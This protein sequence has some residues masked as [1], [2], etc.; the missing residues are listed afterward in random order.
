[1]AKGFKL[2]ELLSRYKETVK[3]ERPKKKNNV[4]K[5]DT[6]QSN[7]SAGQANESLEESGSAKQQD[8]APVDASTT[9]LSRKERRKQK[10]QQKQQ[11]KQQEE[12]QEE[13][14]GDE[15]AEAAPASLDLDKLARSDSESESEDEF[16]EARSV[17]EHEAEDGS[18][19]DVPLSDV[20]FDSDA[21]VVPHQKVT[22]NN[23]KAISD[24]LARIQLPWQ[25][26]SFQEH[27]T[28]TAAANADAGITDI[29]DDTE[30]E[31]AFYKQS[32]DA[33]VQARDAL[34]ALRV[35]FK[36]PLDYFAEMVK[37]DEHMDK[38][39]SKLVKEASD[40]KAREE[41]RKQ[42]QLKK[43]GK[44]VQVATL[45]QRQKEKRETLDKI[46]SLRTKRKH[47]DIDDDAFAVGVEDAAA[48]KPHKAG[49]KRQAKNAKYGQ[50][51]LKRFK[52]KNDAQSSAEMTD[53]STRKMKGKAPRPGK[54]KRSRR[55]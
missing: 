48:E 4:K 27:Q 30:R 54:S 3:G 9:P 36:R 12:Q 23:T 45:Q 29:Y 35:P 5:A 50:G 1:M 21:D 47:N 25:K 8:V 55:H 38:L 11:Q 19:E 42:R 6:Q 53:F 14:S 37:T 13:A 26:H 40:K 41:A 2:K 22:I 52:R 7:E 24:S 34:T 49:A 15:S 32:L 10:K 46:K 20:E 28:V 51:G 31:L 43:F 16:A 17:E 39:K 18:E 33:V 44:Q